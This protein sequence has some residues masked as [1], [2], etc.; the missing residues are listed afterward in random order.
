MYSSVENSMFI[1]CAHLVPQGKRNMRILLNSFI[2]GMP[3]CYG[4]PGH[5][6][7]TPYVHPSTGKSFVSSWDWLVC[8]HLNLYAPAQEG[9]APAPAQ[10]CCIQRRCT[11][12]WCHLLGVGCLHSAP[13]LIGL[14]EGYLVLWSLTS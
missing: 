9:L 2:A 8:R 5:P 1:C 7:K 3:Q 4:N 14:F 13:F 11:E 10:W 12:D 6:G